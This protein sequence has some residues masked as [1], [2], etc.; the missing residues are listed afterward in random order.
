MGSSSVVDHV[1][2]MSSVAWHSPLTKGLLSWW[3]FQGLCTKDYH[4]KWPLIKIYVYIYNIHIKMMV[5]A[6]IYMGSITMVIQIITRGTLLCVCMCVWGR[7]WIQCQIFNRKMGLY[8]QGAALGQVKKLWYIFTVKYYEVFR[9]MKP[10][11]FL[12]H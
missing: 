8:S 10:E 4:C 11:N 7:V 3:H 9:K 12:I 2:S 5:K 6:F 1:L